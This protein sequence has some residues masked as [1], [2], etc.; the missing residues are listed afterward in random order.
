MLTDCRQGASSSLLFH[1]E[2][3]IGKTT[4]LDYAAQRADGVRVLRVEGIESEME[5]AF[6]GLHQL[7]L[8]VLDVIDRLP[9]PQAAAMRA[10]FGLTEDAVHDRFTVGLAVLSMLSEIGAD[11]PLLCLVDDVQW[12]D[13]PSADVLT[14]VARRL[15]AEGTVML[16]AARD[17][18]HGSVA[19]GLPCS[20][21]KGS[22]GRRPRR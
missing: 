1:G 18:A 2:A 10:I 19:K 22:T 7:F 13:R 5:L 15:R 12:L 17:G 21:S 11:A 20:T 9:T 14:F 16:F 6:S 3:G 8:P 4:L